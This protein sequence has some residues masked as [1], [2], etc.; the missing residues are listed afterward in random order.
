VCIICDDGLQHYAL[1]RDLEIAV[2]NSD[3]PV[4][5]GFCLPAGPLREPRSRLDSVDMIVYSGDQ[6]RAN[7]YRLEPDTELSHVVDNGRR[8]SIASLRG[9]Q[10]HAVAA[11]ANPD[12]FFH[13]LRQSGL[14]ITPHVFADHHP[15]RAED[16]ALFSEAPIVMTEK[17]AVKCMDLKL[18]D[19]W[20]YRV[21]AIL[22]DAIAQRFDELLGSLRRTDSA[23][24]LQ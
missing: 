22:D 12:R 14:Q 1:Q 7:G 24:S 9:R 6:R 4:G 15:F 10:I 3:D 11:I 20:Y 19:A 5:N 18:P 8:I 16:F 2:V 23:A 17:D 13:M 21:T